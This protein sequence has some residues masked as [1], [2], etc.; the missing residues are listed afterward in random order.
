MPSTPKLV[1]GQ[2]VGVGCSRIDDGNGLR[3]PALSI[4]RTPKNLQRA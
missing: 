2:R 3:G 1:K 4:A